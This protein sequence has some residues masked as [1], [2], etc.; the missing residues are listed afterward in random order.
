MYHQ[1]VAGRAI[2]DRHFRAVLIL[3]QRL[4]QRVPRHVAFL[5]GAQLI[6]ATSLGFSRWVAAF[7]LAECG[8]L[9]RVYHFPVQLKHLAAKMK[10]GFFAKRNAAN[11]RILIGT[12]IF[13]PIRGVARIELMSRSQD[14]A[15]A[16]YK[17]IFDGDILGLYNSPTVA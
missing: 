5:P 11:G 4:K 15:Y 17:L 2:N 3:P 12:W 13:E 6:S 7:R 10:A 8:N 14:D 16:R 1:Y 9:V